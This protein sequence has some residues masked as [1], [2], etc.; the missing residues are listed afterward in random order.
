MPDSTLSRVT[1]RRGNA[2][3][4]NNLEEEDEKA[5]NK[6]QAKEILDKEGIE[7]TDDEL[8]KVAGGFPILPYPEYLPFLFCHYSFFFYPYC[9]HR[10]T[11]NNNQK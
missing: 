2:L 4:S 5:E 1:S 6:E 9:L 8:E 10:K 7:L 11:R 3:S